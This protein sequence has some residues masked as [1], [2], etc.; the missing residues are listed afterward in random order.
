MNHENG[1]FRAF[2]VAF[3]IHKYRLINSLQQF[4]KLLRYLNYKNHQIYGPISH[5]S[6][7]RFIGNR[8]RMDKSQT[9]SHE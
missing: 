5:L 9:E 8:V 4:R 1:E 6:S 3:I 7:N 2:F